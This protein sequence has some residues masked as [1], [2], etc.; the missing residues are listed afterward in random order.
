MSRSVPKTM[1]SGTQR[2]IQAISELTAYL[3]HAEGVMAEDPTEWH[4]SLIRALTDLADQATEL[5]REL[6]ISA[7]ETG[8]LNVTE[9]ARAAR[10][11]RAAVYNR[12]KPPTS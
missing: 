2:R 7:V 1:R 9:V 8:A 11:T 3:G 4:R 10:L 12:V 6:T 5:E